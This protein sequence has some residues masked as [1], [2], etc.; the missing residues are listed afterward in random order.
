MH[1]SSLENMQK[2]YENYICGEYFSRHEKIDVLDIGGANINGTYADIFSPPNFNYIA[3]DI[4]SGE[5]IDQVLVDPYKLPYENASVDVVISGQAFEHVEFFWLLFEEMAR[6]LSAD[7]WIFLIVPSSGPIHR[8]PVDCYRFYPDAYF[9]LAKYT[10]LQLVEVYRDLRGPWKDLVGV[11]TKSRV[12]PKKPTMHWRPLSSHELNRF[13]IQTAPAPMVERQSD[14]VEKIAGYLSYLDVLRDL[15]QAIKPRNYLE[16]GVRKGGSLKLSKCPSI[17]IDPEPDIDLSQFREVDLFH[18][19]SDCFFENQNIIDFSE[20]PIDLAFIDGMHLFEYVLRDF[21]NIE[22]RSN[23]GAVIVVDDIFPNHIRQASRTRTSQTWTGDVWKFLI[24][25]RDLR[26]DLDLSMI[27]T[28]PAGLLLIRKLKKD[29]GT[30]TENYNPI[31]RKYKDLTI[32]Q[33][34]NLILNRCEALRP[35]TSEYYRLL[36]SLCR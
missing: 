17:A 6:V 11:F 16:I 27:D 25:L 30:L 13:A 26:P 24:C 18:M 19:P 23:P 31:V 14:D 15:H 12:P 4:A 32:E 20:R 1:A 2:C 36:S 3:V 22:I 8:F 34:E 33:Y 7:G 5:G 29:N 35:A 28:R 21:I 10:N 9:A